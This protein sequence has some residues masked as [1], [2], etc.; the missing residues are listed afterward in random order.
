MA[1][2]VGSLVRHQGRWGVVCVNPD[3]N[4]RGWRQGRVIDFWDGGREYVP[5]AA[6]VD[7][8]PNKRGVAA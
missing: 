2:P 1:V 6:V 7:V 8:A 4:L 5:D 3:E